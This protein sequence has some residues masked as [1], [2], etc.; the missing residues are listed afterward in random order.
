MST[1]KEQVYS[2]DYF[3]F[4]IPLGEAYF[5]SGPE[6]CIQRID[7]DF[8]IMYYPREGLPP[9]SIKDYSY[10]EIPKCFGLLDRTALEASGILQLQIQPA[11][12]LTGD[13]VLIGFIDTGIDYT[14]SLFRYEDGSTRIVSIWDQTIEDGTTPLG[15]LYGA[16]YNSEDINKAL[17]SENPYEIVPTRDTNGHGTFLAGVA[18]GGMDLDNDFSGAAPNAQ[19]AVVKL[20]E[21]K[22]YLKD[23]FF[24]K[25]GVPAYQENDIMLAIS[26]LNAL[27]N[28]KNVP[29]VICIGL[30]SANGSRAGESHLSAYLNYLCTR[31]QRAI[32]VATG[33]EA[34]ARHHFAGQLTK[35]MEYEE[36][37]I[38]VAENSK[39]FCAELWAQ[40]P[41]LFDVAVVSPTGEVLEKI[42]ARRGATESYNFI[43]EGTTVSV[44][45]RFGAKIT[46][47]LLIFFRFENATRGIWKIRVY[48]K[49]ISEGLYNIWLPLRQFTEGDIFFLRSNPDITLTVPSAASQVIS[50]GAY[51]A[52]NRS[53]DAD[54]GRGYSTSGVVKPEFAAPGVNVYGPDRRGNYIRQT[55][56][57]VAAAITAG[58]V[59]QVMQWAIVERN[60]PGITNATIKNLLI[61]G[62]TEPAPLKYPNTSWGYGALNV[63][64]S[65]DLMRR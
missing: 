31:R 44:D 57:S 45:Y 19:I 8:D 43:F 1:C 7:E 63:Y 24:I 27:A 62:T 55:G 56:T 25:E 64:Q 30:G 21:A 41:E 51:S 36:V 20:K 22:Q 48:P 61:R 17:E 37:E 9:L 65:F 60:A 59:A 4:I 42:V 26:Y 58:A 13:G 32:V 29:L 11:L 16:Q 12:Q 35:D 53:I 34:G 2:N 15:I 33:N 10:A 54:S 49:E 28:V 23:F 5:L 40:A 38:N 14:N 6:T 50:V 52:V 46:G 18:A 47:S 3:D 39:G